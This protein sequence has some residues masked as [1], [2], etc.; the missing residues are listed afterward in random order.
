MSPPTAVLSKNLQSI[1]LTKIREIEKQRKKYETRKSEILAE[2]SAPGTEKPAR[3]ARLLSGVE[4]LYP[5]CFTDVNVSNIK[6]WLDQSQYD[7]S[8]PRDML[9]LFEEQLQGKLEIQSRKLSL[10]DLY[11]RLLTEWMNPPTPT[12]NDSPIPESSSEDSFELV[13]RQ[14]QRLQELCDKF[15]SVVFEPLDTNETEMHN[16]MNSLFAEPEAAK[17]LEDLRQQIKNE[18]SAMLT[19]PTPFNEESLT[20]CIKGLLTEDLLSD[21]KQSILQEFLQNKVVLAEIADVLNMRFA[22]IKNWDWHAGDEGIPVMPRQQLNGKYRIWMDEDILQTILVQYIGI[23]LCVLLKSAL[24]DFINKKPVWKWGQG[25]QMTQDDIDRRQYYLGSTGSSERRPFF[26]PTTSSR[27]V[28]D[29]RKSDYIDSFFLSQLPSADTSLYEAGG[30]YDNDDDSDDDQNHRH[31]VQRSSGNFQFSRFVQVA[32]SNTEKKEGAKKSGIKQQ[33]LRKI[34]SEVLLYR[35]LQGRVAVVQSDLQWYATALPHSTIFAVMRFVGFSE[36]WIRFFKR[37]LEAP[38]N[39]D[40]SSEDR[41]PAGPRIR[42]RGVPMAHASEKFTGELVLFIMDLAVNKK[43]GMLL[44]R[45]HDDLWL[46]GEPERCV[47]AWDVMGQFAKIMGLEFNRNKTGSVYLTSEAKMKDPKI[48][49]ALPKGP[50]EI[51]FLTLDNETGNWVI[52]QRQVD[53]HVKQL[54]KQL[55]A[56]N[57]VLSWVQ[58]W[59]SCIGRFFSHTFGEP[60]YCFGRQHLDIILKTYECMQRTLFN[61]R[62]GNGNNVTE[63]LKRMMLARFGVSDIPDAFLFL[64]EQLGGLGLRNPF[65]PLFLVREELKEQPEER[66]A[67][68]LGVERDEYSAQK[69]AFEELGEQGRRRRFHSIYQKNNFVSEAAIAP[70]HLDTFMSLEE[71]T[72]F[73]ESTSAS[74]HRIYTRLM[75]VPSKQD[76][77]VTQEVKHALDELEDQLESKVLDPEKKWMVQLHARELFERYGGLSL[78]DKC[79]LPVGVLTMMRG[80][81]VAWQMV[82]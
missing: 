31:T 56:C 77:L 22:D 38:L 7:E 70:D 82:L 71:F 55:T 16:F 58:T 28:D 41:V 60:A 47:Q 64:P 39:M 5:N 62:D 23:R 61:G 25:M 63:H 50:V 11:S 21:E 29:E 57:S 48:T 72:R 80:K 76:I 4:E 81:K 53:A 37:Y 1:T 73:R 19:D 67:E 9:R 13:E 32:G 2:A 74:L 69:K 45:L 17:A 15:E 24:K 44:Y 66:L 49:A 59:N 20:R 26:A 36:D 8:I 14:K 78:V 33:L 51:G 27:S 30:G 42:K 52:N 12:S 18:S 34:A 35:C 75:S 68:F 65:V 10:A 79:F 43:A 40:R 3:V 6:R 54:Q 46:C